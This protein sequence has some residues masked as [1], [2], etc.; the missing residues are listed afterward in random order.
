[1][2]TFCYKSNELW[3]LKHEN[4]SIFNC[5]HFGRF[6]Y[7]LVNVKLSTDEIVYENDTK[8]IYNMSCVSVLTI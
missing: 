8:M 4:A 5:L 6:A 7:Y 1:M 2:C 3:L